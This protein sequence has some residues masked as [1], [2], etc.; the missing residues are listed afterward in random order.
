VR[1]AI[2]ESDAHGRDRALAHLCAHPEGHPR[3]AAACPSPLRAGAQG[4]HEPAIKE[5][6]MAI[7][8]SGTLHDMESAVR[9]ILGANFETAKTRAR[10]QLAAMLTIAQ[11]IEESA[12]AGTISKLEYE[13]LKAS[14]ERAL[15][16]IL[17]AYAAI[18]IAAAEQ[19]AAAAWAVLA[20]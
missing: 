3:P 9:G 12:I 13:S 19:A 1:R 2:A 14:Q 18:G 17:H 20:Q 11:S 15:A 10:A 8:W 7:D 16:G 6:A 5:D 4:R